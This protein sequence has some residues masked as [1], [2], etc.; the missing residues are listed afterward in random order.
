V[1]TAINS[2]NSVLSKKEGDRISLTEEDQAIATSPNHPSYRM[3]QEW[4]YE[5]DIF[6]ISVAVFVCVQY[7]L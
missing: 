7:R 3:P 2:G 5:L 4:G 6:R 1:Q